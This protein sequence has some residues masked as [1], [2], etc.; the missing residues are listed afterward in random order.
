MHITF[1]DLQVARNH[2][3]VE[4]GRGGYG[5]HPIFENAQIWALVD[6][7]QCLSSLPLLDGTGDWYDL[8]K[9]IFVPET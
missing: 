3:F 5:A 6:L 4:D 1:W 9:K 8:Y 2:L 7:R